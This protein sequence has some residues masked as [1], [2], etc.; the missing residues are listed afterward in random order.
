MVIE[1]RFMVQIEHVRVQTLPCPPERHEQVEHPL[2]WISRHRI[3]EK[4]GAVGRQNQIL[5]L[6]SGIQV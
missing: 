1:T 4:S 3:E 6:Q 2:P 5:C